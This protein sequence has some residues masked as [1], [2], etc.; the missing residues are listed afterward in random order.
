MEQKNEMQLFRL[1]SSRGAIADGYRLFLSSFRP[2]LRATWIVAVVYALAAAAFTKS[3]IAMMPQLLIMK[4][5]HLTADTAA[6]TQLGMNMLPMMAASLFIILTTVALTGCGFTAFKEHA[7]SE[8]ISRPAHWYGRFEVKTWLRVFL[9]MLAIGLFATLISFVMGVVIVLSQKYLGALAS[10]LLVG[11]LWLLFFAAY[12]PV[13]YPIYQ[14]MLTPGARLWK[15]LA[16]GYR[17][18]LR[19]WGALF[20]VTLITSIITAMLTLIVE[21]PA[22]ILGMANLNSQLG[23]LQ[24]DPAGM[25]DY[26]GWMTTVVF[27]IAGFIMAYVNLSALFPFYYLYGSVETREEERRKMVSEGKTTTDYSN[28][29]K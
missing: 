21:L 5:Q 9:M 24:G 4:M 3:Y 6:L 11:L 29:Y 13:A 28:D 15:T 25:P 7:S 18:G 16:A 20:V 10:S 17:T 22:I 14:Y 1:R 26:M 23:T 2:L 8:T 27:T 19:H 12:L